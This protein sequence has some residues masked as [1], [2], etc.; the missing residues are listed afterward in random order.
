MQADFVEYAMAASHHYSLVVGNPPYINPKIMEDE[1]VNKAREL[2]KAEG[3]AGAVMQNMWVAFVIGACRVLRP[4][5]AIFFVLPMEFLQVQYAEKLRLYLENRFNTIHIISFQKFIFSDIEQEI[6][7]VYLT[8]KKQCP[9]HILYNIY[10]DADQ[11]KP[12]RTNIIQKIS[13][14]K[15]GP[16]QFFL[17]K[18]LP[19]LKVRLQIIKE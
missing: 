19:Y 3:L 9:P 18:K 1:T 15:S 2:C 17:T 8:N 12:I 16:T 10:Q 14:C 5:G 4:G 7:L 6:C 11:R 13:P